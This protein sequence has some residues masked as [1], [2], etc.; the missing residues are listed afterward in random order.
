M[1]ADNVDY[2]RNTVYVGGLEQSITEDIL[3]A[4]FVPFGNVHDIFIPKNMHGYEQH[5]GF[6]FIT[7]ELLHDA[8]EAVDNMHHSE[9]FGK[10]IKCQLAK[11]NATLSYISSSAP[12]Y[13]EKAIWKDETWLQMNN[14]STDKSS[15]IE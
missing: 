7:F 13:R 1:Y 8:K 10:I 3:H 2:S 15:I 11:P 9:L 6:A 12:S 4:A 14:P 5:R